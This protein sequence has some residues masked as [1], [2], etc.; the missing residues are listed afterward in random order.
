MKPNIF[1]KTYQ[2]G[3]QEH[4]NLNNGF[5]NSDLKFTYLVP[6]D[7]AWENLRTGDFASA[8]KVCFF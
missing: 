2:L 6:T 7:Q 4:F 5:N 3:S 1:S 8:Y